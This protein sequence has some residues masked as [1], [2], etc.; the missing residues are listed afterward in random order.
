MKKIIILIF[1]CLIT[2]GCYNYR[3][4]N[5]LAIVTALGIE[6]KDNKYFVTTQIVNIKKADSETGNQKRLYST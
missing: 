3:E 2:T 1:L 6:K 5:D 4:I